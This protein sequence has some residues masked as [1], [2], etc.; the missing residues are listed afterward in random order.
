MSPTKHWA[1]VAEEQAGIK[2]H[3]KL[4]RSRFAKTQEQ[5]DLEGQP[6]TDDYVFI[7]SQTSKSKGVVGGMVVATIIRNASILMV[8]QT[9]RISTAAEIEQYFEQMSAHRAACERAE[10]E[11]DQRTRSTTLVLIEPVTPIIAEL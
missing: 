9:H 11:R 10:L 6:E 4:L 1:L 7:T 8:G 5:A 2:N 3:I